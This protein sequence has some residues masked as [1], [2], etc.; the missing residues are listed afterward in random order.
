MQKSKKQDGTPPSLLLFAEDSLAS[1]PASQARG[2][3]KRTLDGYG[4]KC[5]ASSQRSSPIGS[6][7]RMCL[8]SF[9]FR[10]RFQ[11]FVW[12]IKKQPSGWRIRFSRTSAKVS[13]KLAMRSKRLLFQLVPLEPSTIANEYGYLPTPTA[14]DR[15][16]PRSKESMDRM[17]AGARKGRKKLSKL[18]EIFQPY[19]QNSFIQIPTP[20][21][22]DGKNRM[23]SQS[24]KNRASIP[25]Y[26]ARSGLST[27]TPVDPRFYERIMG[28]PEGWAT[29]T[30]SPAQEIEAFGNSI[31]PQIPSIFFKLINQIEDERKVDDHSPSS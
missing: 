15:L 3:A 21:A 18:I 17:M 19:E 23:A 30:G 28:Y 27:G 2:Q 5:F 14:M 1:Q 24:Q 8:D 20:T 12:L 10:S 22:N 4:L 31:V 16:P 25:G 11:R 26:L 6:L 29:G 9:P 7:R 13:R